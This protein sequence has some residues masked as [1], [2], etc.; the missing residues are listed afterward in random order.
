MIDALYGPVSGDRVFTDI[1]GVVRF[2][3]QFRGHRP[4]HPSVDRQFFF[5]APHAKT[6]NHLNV[7]L[8][9][10]ADVLQPLPRCPLSGVKR[11]SGRRAYF[12]HSGP[13]FGPYRRIS[14]FLVKVCVMVRI[15][16]GCG[17]GCRTFCCKTGASTIKNLRTS[18]T[19]QIL[20]SP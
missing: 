9:S 6:D 10:K 5:L 13:F 15:N 7:R 19:I 14:V 2:D 8:G 4:V 20:L 11:T 12:L 17:N 3:G 18:P 16:V 1:R